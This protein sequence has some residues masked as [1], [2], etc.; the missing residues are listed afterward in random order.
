M[1]QTV[2]VLLIIGVV[3]YLAKK[4]VDT[5]FSKIIYGTTRIRTGGIA[6]TTTPG[7]EGVGL[8]V[9]VIQPILN[10]NP[11]SVTIDAINGSM[12]YGAQKLADFA[13]PAPVTLASG[14]TVDLTFKGIL[15]FGQSAEAINNMISTGNWLQSLRFKGTATS[16]GITL[17]FDHTVSIG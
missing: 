9:E 14:Q 11:V 4:A 7:S 8:K 6:V 12:Y 5:V 16:T 17:P 13:L 2:K 10:E 3:F 1:N 15:D